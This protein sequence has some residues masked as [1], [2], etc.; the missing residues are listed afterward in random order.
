MRRFVMRSV[1]ALCAPALM[2]VDRAD[3]S[4]CTAD[5]D[6][7][8]V[9][10]GIDLGTLLANWPIPIGAPACGGASPCAADLNRDG[11]VDGIDFGIL[12]AQWGP[13]PPIDIAVQSI[14]Q[15]LNGGNPHT[16]KVLYFGNSR[17]ARHTG[18][19]YDGVEEIAY[20]QGRLAGNGFIITRN[21]AGQTEF[22]TIYL[23]NDGG[24]TGTTPTLGWEAVDPISMA[25]TH[26]STDGVGGI[27]TATAGI[28]LIPNREFKIRALRKGLPL[29]PDDQPVTLTIQ[30]LAGPGMGVF[31]V[32]PLDVTAN[33]VVVASHPVT[34]IN[35]SHD[36]YIVKWKHVEIPPS[37]GSIYHRTFRISG[38]SG[39]TT[40]FRANIGRDVA[41]GIAISEMGCGGFGYPVQ[42]SP[43]TIYPNSWTEYVRAFDPDIAIWQYAANQGASGVVAATRQLMDR[44]E[45][46]NPNVVHI[47][48]V[49]TP[50]PFLP[51][52]L[53]EHSVQWAA[54]LQGYHDAIVVDPRSFLPDLFLTHASEQIYGL[55]FT[56]GYHE[57]RTGASVVAN[58]IWAALA[59][60]VNEAGCR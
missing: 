3:A 37:F 20:Q 26:A 2:S 5:I 11:T 18:F 7:S 35:A 60:F 54:Q 53:T 22:D 15:L 44:V 24:G 40:V 19:A 56:D 46:V 21:Y 27:S 45:S 17:V 51:L 8:L 16:L 41:N 49:D 12:L 14:D 39:N 30:Y 36:S 32:E 52:A 9:V 6:G 55:Y 43:L 33:G 57:S 50:T 29:L 48:C 13:V 58:A 47:V 4:E 31:S 59:E 1:L 28:A 34:M 38:V 42:A 23:A 10:D 25:H